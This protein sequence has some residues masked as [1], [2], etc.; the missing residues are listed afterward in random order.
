[1]N[2]IEQPW[3]FAHVSE[4]GLVKAGGCVIHRISINR[5]DSAAEYVT[6]YDGLDATGDVVAI[7]GIGRDAPTYVTPVSLSFDC[8][9]LVGCYVEFDQAPSIADLTIA[10]I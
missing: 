2:A 9:L 8:R 1:M 4:S 7:I 3:K 5:A 10:Y 6:I